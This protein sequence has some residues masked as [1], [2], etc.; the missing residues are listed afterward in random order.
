MKKILIS[1]LLIISIFVFS[2]GVV[3]GQ[4]GVVYEATDDGIYRCNVVYE[5]TDDADHVVY[6]ATDD[7][8][9]I[10]IDPTDTIEWKKYQ[11][12]KRKYFYP[13]GSVELDNPLGVTS[14]SDIIVEIIRIL[15]GIIGTVSLV[16]FIYGGITILT[17]AGNDTKIKTGKETLI[18]ASLGILLVFASYVILRFVLNVVGV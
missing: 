11:E 18:W 17:S 15:L 7:A 8:S 4:D 14:I 10:K 3:F 13:E 16:M 1:F 6:E 9:C 12:Y 5:A 2:G